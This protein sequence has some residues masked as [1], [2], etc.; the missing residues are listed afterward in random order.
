MD[1]V[2][3]A[4]KALAVRVTVPAVN[5]NQD[6][7]QPTAPAGMKII[8][9]LGSNTVLTDLKNILFNLDTAALY[10]VKILGETPSALPRKESEKAK[11]IDS[12]IRYRYVCVN[13][14]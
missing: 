8:Q 7:Q 1:L 3:G 9:S 6:P 2:R 11:Y 10:L 12:A 14:H 5:P 13:Y 4:Q